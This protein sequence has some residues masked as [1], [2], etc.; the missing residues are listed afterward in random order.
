MKFP[1]KLIRIFVFGLVGVSLGETRQHDGGANNPTGLGAAVSPLQRFGS[2]EYADGISLPGGTNRPEARTISNALMPQ[3]SD[4]SNSRDLSDFIW[5]WGQF[6]DHD[7]TLIQGNVSEPMSIPVPSPTDVL[8]P[9]PIPTFRSVSDPLSGLGLGNPRQQMNHTTSFLDASMVYGPDATRAAALRT[10]VGGKMKMSG[11]DERLL[12]RNTELFPMENFGASEDADLFFAG[13]VRANEQPGLTS[14]HTVFLREHNRWADIVASEN[15]DWSDEQIYQKA[16]RIVGAEVQAVTYGEWLPSLLGPGAPTMDST[17]Y[18]GT[19]N[20]GIANEFATAFY[21]LGHT[22]VS[23]EIKRVENDGSAAVGGN[24]NLM[25]SFFDPNIIDSTREVD[26]T[27][28]GLASHRAQEVD[29]HIVEDLRSSLFGEPG[30][31]GLDLASINIARGREHGLTDYNSMREIFGLGRVNEFGEISSDL[32]VVTTLEL[33]YDSVDDIDLWV[34]ALAEDHLPGASVGELLTAGLSAQFSLLRDGDAF[35]FLNDEEFSTEEIA[36]IRDTRLSDI[37]SRNT[38]L[39]TL[40]PNV[41]FVV[42]EPSTVFLGFLG[43]LLPL[44]RRRSKTLE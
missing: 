31:G 17:G 41:F 39:T 9:G 27:I 10:G 28:K 44:R 20:P 30:A 24:H 2:E 11:G 15:P 25:D 37:L 5:Q 29:T 3:S 33:L 43:L 42:P 13:D 40:Q 32:S 6:I 8:A 38:S 4:M 36:M 35:Y 14:M 1:L 34:G 18:D 21:R 7:M 22:L 26:V 19:L 23:S 16:R 12:P